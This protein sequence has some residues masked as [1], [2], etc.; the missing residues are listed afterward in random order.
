MMKYK[1]TRRKTPKPFGTGQLNRLIDDLIH[2]F[3]EENENLI[4]VDGLL[5]GIVE[6]NPAISVKKFVK[7]NLPKLV[8]RKTTKKSH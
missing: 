5:H 1:K 8:K 7:Y 3:F 2:P 4:W 6:Q